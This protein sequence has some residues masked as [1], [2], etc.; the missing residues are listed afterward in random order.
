[1]LCGIFSRVVASSST[2]FPL[3]SSSSSASAAAFR[4]EAWPEHRT[5]FGSNVVL[6]LKL[7][8]LLP[9]VS[10]LMSLWLTRLVCKAQITPFVEMDR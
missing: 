3:I 7:L 2:D 6:L 5:V 8:L 9:G 10:S 4:G 1:M